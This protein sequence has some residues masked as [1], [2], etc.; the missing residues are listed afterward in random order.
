MVIVQT[1]EGPFLELHNVDGNG[2][3][4]YVSVS[5]LFGRIWDSYITREL[6]DEFTRGMLSEMGLNPTEIFHIMERLQMGRAEYD[7][8]DY[9]EMAYI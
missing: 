3:V 5:E 6:P 7:R 9:K 1:E 4:N 2:T 8:N